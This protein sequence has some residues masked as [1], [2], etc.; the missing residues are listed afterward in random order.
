MTSLEKKDIEVVINRLKNILEDSSL[1]KT[2]QNIK[3][4][5]HVLKR[6]GVNVQGI[7]FDTMIAAHLLNPSAKSLSLDNLSLE[8]LNYGSTIK[9]E[10]LLG[11][12]KNKILMHEVPLEK[13]AIY[14]C[15]NADLAIQLT[16]ILE[17]QL[18]KE[19]LYDF[20]TIE[21]PLIPF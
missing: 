17:E 16:R 20:M 15:E 11:K 3:Y 19:S 18:K 12:G 10:E 2:G 1:A 13:S 5:L 21:L 4:D 7:A 9:I 8:F 14:A 6:Y